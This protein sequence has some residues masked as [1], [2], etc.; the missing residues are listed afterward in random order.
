MAALRG[1]RGGSGNLAS[2]KEKQECKGLIQVVSNLEK[3]MS[4]EN[5]LE[6]TPKHTSIVRESILHQEKS[7]SRVSV[8]VKS[9]FSI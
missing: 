1:G 5:D 6:K 8:L 7:D 4:E 2:G 9:S 3:E